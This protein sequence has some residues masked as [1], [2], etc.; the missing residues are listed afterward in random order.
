M[1]ISITINVDPT[2]EQL[3]EEVAEWSSDKQ[4]V[5]L[6]KLSTL[7]GHAQLHYVAEEL[8]ISGYDISGLVNQLELF[9][10]HIKQEVET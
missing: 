4:A 9:V 10:G 5:F 1:S 7:V 8:A 6:R 2:P 3:A